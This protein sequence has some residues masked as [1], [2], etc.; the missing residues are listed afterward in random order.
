MSI[1]EKK[2]LSPEIVNRILTGPRFR[3]NDSDSPTLGQIIESHNELHK[4]YESAKASELHRRTCDTCN[5]IGC[6][7]CDKTGFLPD[8]RGKASEQPET[9]QAGGDNFTSDTEQPVSCAM[10][11]EWWAIKPRLPNQNMEML[12]PL[13]DK[14]LKDIEIGCMA[15]LLHDSEHEASLR[16]SRILHRLMRAEKQLAELPTRESVCRHNF[17]GY[18]F[19]TYICE[20]CGKNPK[21]CES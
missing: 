9:L 7:N 10:F 2:I 15:W 3:K 4:A 18:D 17:I 8:R 19:K 12:E 13:G 20:L 11:D 21:E 14:E 6:P 1:D 5:G 16:L